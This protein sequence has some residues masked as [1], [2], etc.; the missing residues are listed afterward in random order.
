MLEVYGALGD[1]DAEEFKKCFS[2]EQANTATP[3]CKQI[4][5]GQ[6]AAP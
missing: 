6:T 4:I 3:S 5:C 2:C 1:G